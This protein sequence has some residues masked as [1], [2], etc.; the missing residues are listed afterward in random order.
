[1]NIYISGPIT[2]IDELLC[3]RNFKNAE[4]RI[5]GKGHIPVNPLKI[6]MLLPKS[7]EWSDYLSIDIEIMKKCNAVVFLEGWENSKGCQYEH[8]IAHNYTK[9]GGFQVFYGIHEIPINESNN[10]RYNT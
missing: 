6:G 4:V 7:F 2:G 8:S 1:M 9:L 5:M 10:R 3:Y